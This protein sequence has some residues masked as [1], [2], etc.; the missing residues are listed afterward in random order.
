MSR[1]G[2]LSTFPYTHLAHETMN[3]GR[4][5]D[6]NFALQEGRRRRH[7]AQIGLCLTT[8]TPAALQPDQ[9]TKDCHLSMTLHKTARDRL[10]DFSSLRNR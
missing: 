5:A 1:N 8:T 2:S 4:K 9:R 10:R 7:Y 3:A 6:S